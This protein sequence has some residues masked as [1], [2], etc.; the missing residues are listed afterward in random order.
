MKVWIVPIL[1]LMSKCLNAQV[2]S[3]QQEILNYRNREVQLLENGRL[4][5]MDLLNGGNEE[6]IKSVMNLLIESTPNDR[7]AFYPVEKWFLYYWTHQYSALMN[8]LGHQATSFD[9]FRTLLRPPNDGLGASLVEKMRIKR[10]LIL[11]ELKGNALAEEEKQF[12]LLH[13]DYILGADPELAITQ[14]EINKRSNEFL[15]AYPESRFNKFIRT[16]IRH[17]YVPAKWGMGFEFCFG[18]AW[19]NK[20]LEANFSKPFIVGMDFDVVYKQ[21]VL[22]LRNCIGFGKIRRDLLYPNITWTK[23]ARTEVFFPEASL[24]YNFKLRKSFLITP[25][26]GLTSCSIAPSA[27]DQRNEAFDDVG[28]EFTTSYTLGLNLDYIPFFKRTLFPSGQHGFIRLRYG[29]NIPQFYKKYDDFNGNAH[30][31]T[32]GF[33]AIYRKM[34]RVE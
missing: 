31:L 8:E 22:Y 30:Y 23:G 13:L 27:K 4:M 16:Y 3:I 19:F 15:I 2:D 32:I 18:K 34:K 29:Y 11:D 21:W 24:G 9:R 10:I 26:A 14:D 28:L 33:G 17:E 20:E 7:M 12:L 5:I 25:F 1:L 6:K